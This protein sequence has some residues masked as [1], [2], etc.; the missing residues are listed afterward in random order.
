MFAVI[1]E[2]QPKAEKWDDYLG[3]AKEM[4][5]ILEG[6]D[7]FVDNERFRSGRVEGRLLSLSTWRDEKSVVRWRTE[8]RHHQAQAKGRG[9]IF[10]DYHLRVGEIVADTHV[11][12]GHVLR[13]QR[14]DETETG[15]AKAV[16]ISEMAPIS[17][18]AQAAGVPPEDMDGVVDWDLYES[19]TTPGKRLLLVS[20]TDAAAASRWGPAGLGAE[21][22]RHRQVRIVRDYGMDDR[23]EAPQWYPPRRVVT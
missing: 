20:W 16:T 15:T 9:D 2:V 18:A 22:V 5:P 19:I 14:L 11:P 17:G 6:I 10:A 13:E 4:R 3:I 1:F 7:G 21:G 23:R 8:G 12:A